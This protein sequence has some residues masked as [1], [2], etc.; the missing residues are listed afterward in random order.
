MI[1]PR[2][3]E[4]EPEA[5]LEKLLMPSQTEAFFAGGGGFEQ[6]AAGQGLTYEHRPQQ[7]AMARAVAD[8]LAAS[9]HLA[10]EAGTGVGKSF[11][12]LVPLILSALERNQPVVA[13]TYTIS[14]QEQLINKD[15]PFLQ[16][17]LGAPFRAE[18]VKGRSNYLCW[19]RFERA[20]KMGGDLFARGQ[21]QQLESIRD[22]VERSGKGSLQDLDAQPPPSVW[23][24]ICGEHDNCM[25]KR[26]P[27]YD[28]C[29][30]IR[31]RQRLFDA[32]LIVANH[33]LCF[34][35]LALRMRGGSFLPRYRAIVFDE[36]HQVEH[37]A[38]EHF[39]IRLSSFAFKHWMRRLYNPAGEKGLLVALRE[40][41]A[42]KEVSV[43]WDGVDA[44][45][46]KIRKWANLKQH[47][48]CRTV[49]KPLDID[50]EIPL[51]MRRLSD[52]LRKIGKTVDREDLKLEL[53]A[54]RR[55]GQQMSEEL[56]AFIGQKMDD[57]VYWVAREG[58]R[59]FM[60]L[61][62]APIVVGPVLEKHLFG[63][64]SC[65]VMTSA[66]LSVAGDLSYFK[67]RVGAGDAE[68]L[69]VGSPFDYA[70]QMEI[71]IPRIMPN[72]N[73][74]KKY[75]EHVAHAVRYFINSTRGRAFVLFTSSRLMH[76]VA[77]IV[78]P[79][80]EQE[81]YNLYVQGDGLSRQVMLDK[82]REEGSNVLFGVDSFW[83]G[84][85]VRGPALSNVIITRLPF[86]V[87]DQPLIRA[88][89]DRIREQGGNPF[90]DYSLPEAILKF[91][92]GVGRLIRTKTDRGIIVIL[93]RRVVDKWYGRWFLKSLPECP[94]TV[95]DVPE[96]S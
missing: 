63:K 82:F 29:V 77:D 47:E 6:A 37:V 72:P 10:V 74:E 49:D 39:G 2:Q 69:S 28:R 27:Y 41:Q 46:K 91:R 45:F 31:A 66:T 7:D 78:T 56:E 43:M 73:D 20:L 89:M 30:F 32:H 8:A 79:W 75:P 42:A 65:V 58:R 9:H 61:H 71:R 64:L 11:A 36:A 25:Q 90:R 50:T 33:H 51:H 44:F 48:S 17:Y 84:V 94:V 22:E 21:L 83:M 86:A 55:R 87:P 54:V 57:H 80:M 81:D 26:C 4:P 18:L 88:R 24:Q 68:A 3:N 19:R 60:V 59:Q 62:S 23:T 38:S 35:E 92:Q 13:S 34:A 76:R 15:I 67:D 85:D 70:R 53:E 52:L 5:V 16:D 40:G 95:V 1:A 93:D 12:Y 14:L 96:E